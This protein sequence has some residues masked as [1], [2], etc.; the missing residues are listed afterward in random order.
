MNIH[1]PA[2]LGFTGYQGFDPSP[3]EKI[4]LGMLKGGHLF[5]VACRSEVLPASSQRCSGSVPWEPSPAVEKDH[6]WSVVKCGVIPYGYGSKLGTPIIGMV[7]TELDIHICGPLNGL[8]FWPTSIQLH[9]LIFIHIS[10][11]YLWNICEKYGYLCKLNRITEYIKH[12]YPYLSNN[13]KT[14]YLWKPSSMICGCVKAWVPSSENETHRIAFIMKN[15][16][17]HRNYK[18]IALKLLSS[19]IKKTYASR[20]CLF[21]IGK[22]AFSEHVLA[23]FV[24]KKVVWSRDT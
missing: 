10:S 5:S 9:Y 23:R 6:G 19:G 3:Y 17:G 24:K 20:K 1:L 22:S 12:I 15:R 13:R 8:P 11:G 4:V 14:D 18:W 7:N 2:I 21:S 16:W